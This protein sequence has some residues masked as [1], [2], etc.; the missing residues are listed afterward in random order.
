MSG[1]HH[2]KNNRT[3]SSVKANIFLTDASFLEHFSDSAFV[4]KTQEQIIKD[5]ELSGHQFHSVLRATTYSLSDL[6]EIVAEMLA[7]ALKMGERQTSQLLYQIDIPESIYL[8]LSQDPAFLSK[9]SLKII[10]RSAYKV[11]LRSQF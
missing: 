7:D 10:Q 6:T 1:Q 3:F 8:E 11:Y 4:L 9:M 5:F 2:K